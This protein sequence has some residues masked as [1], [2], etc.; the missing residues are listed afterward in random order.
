MI[1][2]KMRHGGVHGGSA[3]VVGVFL[4]YLLL[5]IGLWF[6]ILINEFY[7]VLFVILVE[8]QK[9][10]KKIYTKKEVEAPVFYFFFGIV[11]FVGVVVVGNFIAH[12]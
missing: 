12:N 11:F 4:D 5:F 2:N 3:H 10:E 6:E 7:K 1:F 9:D 8:Y